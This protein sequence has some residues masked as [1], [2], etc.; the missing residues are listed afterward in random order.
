MSTRASQ[1]MRQGM[2]ALTAFARPLDLDL[3]QRTLSPAQMALFRA[4][5]R[6]EQL[7][8]LR[9]LHDLLHDGA[10]STPDDLAVAA[11]LHD[12]GKAR[13]SLSVAEK[14]AAVLIRAGAPKRAAHYG[15]LPLESAGW[16][17]AF[18]VSAQHP[19]WGAQLLA[20]AGGTERAVWLVAH[21]ADPLHHWADHPHAALLARLQ[22][23]DD[24][25]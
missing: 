16:R 1:R 12:A 5:Q 15:T 9:V 6:S 10:A 18:V 20:A 8:S 4:M 7:H 19:A 13:C 21:H 2:A 24:S 11:L 3:A 17:R 23:A 22:A 14:T 25:N